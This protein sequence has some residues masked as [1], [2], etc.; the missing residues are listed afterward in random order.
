MIYEK[1][2]ALD[3]FNAYK[4][5][6]E[7]L[8]DK[9][10]KTVRSHHGREYYGRCDRSSKQSP[11]PFVRYLEEECGIINPQYMVPKWRS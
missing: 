11:V 1:S 9:K 7:N 2:Q 3:V 6:V 5:K 4:A 10:P 8:L